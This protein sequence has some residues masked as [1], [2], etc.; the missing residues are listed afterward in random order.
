[1]I[2]FYVVSFLL[3]FSLAGCSYKEETTADT[4]NKVVKPT[5]KKSPKTETIKND[6]PIKQEHKVSVDQNKVSFLMGK[7]H[8]FRTKNTFPKEALIDLATNPEL[9][10]FMIVCFWKGDE[11][12]PSGCTTTGWTPDLTNS[13]IIFGAR[14]L[15]LQADSSALS[16]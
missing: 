3:I 5:H 14:H 11:K 2:R 7:L 8:A 6:K 9:E 1:M 13:E 4:N 15:M 16:I 10:G 12:T